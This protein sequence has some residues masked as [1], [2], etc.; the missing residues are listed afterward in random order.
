MKFPSNEDLK[1][2]LKELEGKDATLVIDYENSSK[3][4]VLKYKLCQ[5]F[6]KILKQEDITQAEL[7]RKVGVDKSIINK[8]ILHKI[9]SFT[10][11]RLVDL[12]SSIKTVDI[13]LS[14]S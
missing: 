1:E 13:T 8:I 9:E 14:A 7:S 2:T 5:E 3:S 10:V 12:L 11:D 4:D 6:T